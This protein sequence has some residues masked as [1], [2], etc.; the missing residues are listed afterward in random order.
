MPFKSLISTGLH[1]HS[2]LLHDMRCSSYSVKNSFLLHLC[3][4]T[5]IQNHVPLSHMEVMAAVPCALPSRASVTAGERGQVCQQR[6]SL[7]M[8]AGWPSSALFI[9]HS[10]QKGLQG[11][12]GIEFGSDF[13]LRISVGNCKQSF[14]LTGCKNSYSGTL[15]RNLYRCADRQ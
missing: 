5:S 10:S 6:R 8:T 1:S 4:R 13:L 2:H 11:L 9:P 15:I 3:A 14:R 12:C 7:T